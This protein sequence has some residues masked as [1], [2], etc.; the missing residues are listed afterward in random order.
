MAALPIREWH[1]VDAKTFREEV[2]ARYEPAVLRGVVADWPAVRAAAESPALFCTYVAERDSGAPV[3]TLRTP[4][5]AK[6]RIF[7]NDALTGFNFDHE[8]IP[9]TQVI[10]RIVKY[11]AMQN[12]PAVAAQSA[13]LADCA[14]SFAAENV[15]LLVAPTVQP[16]IWLGSGVVTP[17][18]FDE[19]SNV[20]CV[21]AGRRR[22]TLL[23]PEQVGN[24]Y[25]GPL[26]F[27]PTGTPISLVSFREP[28]FARFPRFRDAL[29]ASQVAELGPGDAIYIPPLW[30]HHVESLER[31]NALV[32][33]WWYG[34]PDAPAEAA[35]AFDCLHQ[36]VRTFKNASAEQRAAWDALF[37]HFVF[38][39]GS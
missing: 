7:Y 22:F 11:A 20:A 17:A 6:G 14:P 13:L 8:R 3:D 1:D 38:R 23:P 15:L 25:I 4:P 27:A 37:G 29:A 36:S 2:A 28:D 16:R 35:S 33:Y 5:S 34:A 24:L 21:V 31:L 32:N 30:W 18:H 26:D 19:S 12:P 9:L 39:R 10:E